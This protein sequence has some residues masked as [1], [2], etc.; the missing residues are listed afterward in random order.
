MHACRFCL[1]ALR[2]SL[3][4][5]VLSFLD[6]AIRSTKRSRCLLHCKGR[7]SIVRDPREEQI[8]NRPRRRVKSSFLRI[9]LRTDSTIRTL[10]GESPSL[11]RPST[12]VLRQTLGRLT[13]G[14]RKPFV[15]TVTVGTFVAIIYVHRRSAWSIVCETRRTRSLLEF[16]SSLFWKNDDDSGLHLLEVLDPF[17]LDFFPTTA[18]N[19]RHEHR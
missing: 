16:L 9:S 11:T 17:L 7:D 1:S 14:S 6:N 19:T 4:C 12:C 8:E 15:L 10:R 13:W 18:N 2:C 3:L 5:H